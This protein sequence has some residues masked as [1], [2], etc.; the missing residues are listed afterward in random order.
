MTLNRHPHSP[1]LR[2]PYWLLLSC[3]LSTGASTWALPPPAAY[4]ANS[5]DDTVS[6]IALD[7]LAVIGNNW[8]GTC[9]RPWQLPDGSRVYVVNNGSNDLS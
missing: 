8:C 9:A 7:S 3:W 6:V 4:V 1:N 5:G 2:M